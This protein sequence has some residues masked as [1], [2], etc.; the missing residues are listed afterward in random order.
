MLK[1]SNTFLFHVLTPF[2]TIVLQKCATYKKKVSTYVVLFIAL[3]IILCNSI[4]NCTSGIL[5]TI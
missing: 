2:Q 4:F 1:K 3:M 5:K